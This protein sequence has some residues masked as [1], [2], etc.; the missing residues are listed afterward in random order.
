MSVSFEEQRSVY[1]YVNDPEWLKVNSG[2]PAMLLATGL[3]DHSARMLCRRVLLLR[4][5]LKLEVWDV[6][7]KVVATF[8][9]RGPLQSSASGSKA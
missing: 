3:S 5:D 8:Q 7:H 4:P 2:H 6:R 1:A 9:A